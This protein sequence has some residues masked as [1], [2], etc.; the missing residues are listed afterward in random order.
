MAKY[1]ADTRDDIPTVI[2]WDWPCVWTFDPIM[3]GEWRPSPGKGEMYWGQ[4]DWVWY[5]EISDAEAERYMEQIREHYRERVARGEIPAEKKPAPVPEE[6][7]PYNPI[8]RTIPD[9]KRPDFLCHI[10]DIPDALEV[11][12]KFRSITVK[13]YGSSVCLPSG[14]KLHDNVEGRYYTAPY[15]DR[16]LVRCRDCGALILVQNTC[17][18]NIYDGFEYLHDLIPVA[19][20][21]EADLLNILLTGRE[22][23]DYPFCR[24]KMVDYTACRWTDGEE[25]VPNDP[26]E[27]KKRIREKYTGVNRE[28]LEKLIRNGCREVK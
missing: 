14:T 24:I 20:E 9:R 17:D 28:Q 19:S 6:R 11:R 12:K 2:R 1:A 13:K 15:G 25:P 4:G 27:L 23:T 21:E 3:E 5:D 22:F 26:E 16:E 8:L 7:K 18:P 10:Y